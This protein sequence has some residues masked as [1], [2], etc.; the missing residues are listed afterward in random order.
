MKSGG[1]QS[2]YILYYRTVFDWQQIFEMLCLSEGMPIDNYLYID[3]K[4]ELK[5]YKSYVK[6]LVY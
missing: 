5:K 3:V 2:A 4:I 1:L 6:Q